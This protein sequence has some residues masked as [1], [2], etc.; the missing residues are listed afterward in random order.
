MVDAIV[1]DDVEDRAQAESV[2]VFVS[3]DPVE[4]SDPLKISSIAFAAGD[5]FTISWSGGKAPYTVQ[6]MDGLLW[7]DVQT[8]DETSIT[9]TGQGNEGFYRIT[10]E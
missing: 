2:E 9:L 4:P 10:S 3:G 7:D 6:R 8:T 5:S 1:F